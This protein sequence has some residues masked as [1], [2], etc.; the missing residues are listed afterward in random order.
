MKIEKIFLKFFEEN[1]IP[2]ENLRPIENVYDT[3]LNQLITYQDMDRW[4]YYILYGDD[5][6]EERTLYSL[7]LGHAEFVFY[8]TYKDSPMEGYIPRIL[9]GEFIINSSDYAIFTRDGIIR[10]CFGDKLIYGEVDEEVVGG[11]HKLI[12]AYESIK[13][14]LRFYNVEKFD[15]WDYHKKMTT[16]INH[17]RMI[18]TGWLSTEKSKDIKDA[19]LKKIDNLRFNGVGVL[20]VSR[21]SS[22]S[23]VEYIDIYIDDRIKRG[24]KILSSMEYYIEIRDKRL[25]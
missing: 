21:I 10:G 2:L 25:L 15:P 8:D 9:V 1:D 5:I 14:V 23:M 11:Y 3:Q 12:K 19:L 13:P 7:G 24:E 22:G 6:I 16:K 4:K 18:C 17:W 20:I